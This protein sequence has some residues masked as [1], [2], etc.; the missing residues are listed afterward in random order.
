M[1][2]NYFKI[3]LRN[4]FKHKGYAFINI[5]GLAIGM[6]CCLLIS[7]WVLDELSFD[8]FH[9]N[10]PDL[11]RVEENQHYSG[12]VYHVTVTPHPLGPALKSEISG[13]QDA[14]RVVWAG[15]HLLRYEDK[16]F[17][18]SDIRGVDPSFLRMFTFPLIR[19]ESET[20]LNSPFSLVIS[21][22]MADKYFPGEDPL[23]KV[24]SVN[25]Q[26]EFTVTGSF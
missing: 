12:R 23:G 2:L 11:Y 3:T 14:A 24:V 15:G 16:V 22:D 17:F 5:A 4:I 26:Y 13:I 8:T 1:L 9:A 25:N 19:G 6:A 20:A 7:I 10:A 21:E 18:E